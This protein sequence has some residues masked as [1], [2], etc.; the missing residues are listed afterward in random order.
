M[1]KRRSFL[2]VLALLCITL[3][4]SAGILPIYASESVSDQNYEK[5]KAVRDELNAEMEAYLTLDTTKDNAIAHKTNAIIGEYSK[6]AIDLY[7][8]AEAQSTD[9]TERFELILAKGKLAGKISWIA[10][11]HT[12]ASPTESILAKHTELR[13]KLDAK[14][15]IRDF[16]FSSEFPNT[17]CIEM[18]RA[19][20][21]EKLQSEARADD[22]AKTSDIFQNGVA[23]IELCSYTD[24][25]GAEFLTI[26]NE[27]MRIVTL[28]RS[29]DGAENELKKIYVIIKGEEAG[30]Y[31]NTFVKAFLNT[32]DGNLHVDESLTIKD[33]N[34]A[35]ITAANGILDTEIASGAK[36][37]FSY[38]E[39]VKSNFKKDAM[40]AT[41][42]GV[43][44][45]ISQNLVNFKEDIIK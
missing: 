28:Q 33:I 11:L 8:S 26:Y 23:R 37:V 1:N 6:E 43:F 5:Y 19:V 2:I 27:I 12:N 7:S 10:N 24:I 40:L 3:L 9:L 36:Y 38:R 16:A 13:A 25:D 31:E 30:F 35:L 42:S 14:T 15:D 44:A 22:S 41:D 29:R 4:S 34:D 20:F 17:V 21:R 18:N 45:P 32:V 39:T